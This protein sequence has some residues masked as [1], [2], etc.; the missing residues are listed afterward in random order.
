MDLKEE[1]DFGGGCGGGGGSES[2]GGVAEMCEPSESESVSM[3]W[4]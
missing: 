3:G 2:R 1:G 4:L